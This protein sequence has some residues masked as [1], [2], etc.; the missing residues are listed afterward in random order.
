[1]LARRWVDVGCDDAA[2]ARLARELGIDPLAARV[3]ACRGLGDPAEAQRFLDPRLADLPDPFLMSGMEGAVA[4]LARALAAGERIALYGDYDVDGVTSTVLLAG[5]LRAAG[6]DVVTYV[7]HRLV[8]GYGLN[9][10]AVRRLAEGGA[11]LLVSLDCGITSVAEVRA[12]AE[13]GLD[14]VVVDH[15]TVPVELPA[16]VAILNPHQPG[17]TYP[18]KPL[19]AVGVTFCLAMAL[20]KRLRETGWFGAARPEPNL[21]EA[22][23]LVALGTVA[24]VVALT[25]VNRILVRWG[26][27][28]L[29]R[30]RR[31][32]LRALKRVAGLAEGAAVGAGQVGFRLGPRLNA[33]G[34]L[35]DAGRGVRLLL[36][37]DEAEAAA[38]ADELDRENRARQDLERQILEEAVAQA[39][40]RL[41]AGARGLVLWRDSWHPGVV[42]I[43][44][45]RI[46]ERFHRPAV[47]VGVAE[48]VGKGS[49]RS[50]EAFHLHE[51]LTACAGHL[52]RFGGH[53]HAAGVTV[54]PAA[55]PA[56]RA[57]FEAFAAAHLTDEDLVPRC[58]IEGRFELEAVSEQAALALE[59]LA[60]FGAGHPEPLFAVRATPRRARTVGAGGAHLKL[61]LRPGLD[62]I[63]F[64]LG[65]RLA[66]CGG[67]I[68]AAVTLGF[69]DWDG[70]RRLQLRIRDLRKPAP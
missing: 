46:V 29:A 31:P 47:L 62:A 56:F 25:G 16:A 70:S 4:R 19:A 26:L 10:A 61:A 12:A 55:L 38:L 35:D 65:D 45:S 9:T 21:R 43:V 50:I 6:G 40:E 69:D 33:A 54:D 17:C 34:R 63:G 53:K 48:G 30:T 58:R 20:R 51:A 27:E 68:E 24:D 66:A 36:S 18:F 39:E 7:P 52:Q 44:A 28:E 14:A 32:G 5:F 57:A 22:L 2:A 3:L 23:D 42:G 64:S 11:K 8:E 59:R 13:L 49:G 60:P 41:A 15:H 67:E 37:R 1:M